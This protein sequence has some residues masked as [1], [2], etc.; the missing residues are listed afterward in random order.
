MADILTKIIE[1]KRQE[2][3]QL[4]KNGF[5]KANLSKKPDRSLFTALHASTV[6]GIIAEIKR[7]SPSKGEIVSTVEPAEQA[8][9][10]EQGGASAISVLTDKDFFNGSIEDLKKVRREVDL[11]LL[12]K[13]FFIDEIQIDRAKDAGA[14]IILLI[15]AALPQGRLHE[16]NQY[17]LSQGLEVLVEI[18]DEEEAERAAALG[19]NIIGI[20]NRNLK[21]F[22]IDLANTERL[23]PLLNDKDRVVISESG[24]KT[25][26]DAV[27]AATAGADGV[28]VGESLM[29]SS[30]AGR[31]IGSF[32]VNKEA[33][34]L[35]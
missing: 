28:L 22:E 12:C 14:N 17:A 33:A 24:M 32:A 5:E 7:A 6:L 27:R 20:N 15:V 19:P 11:P 13:D 10:Y 8:K 26:E 1:R 21:T 3:A 34:L 4:K 18:H 16:L 29:R 31:A 2:V 9:I 23:A 35:G 30:D 25:R